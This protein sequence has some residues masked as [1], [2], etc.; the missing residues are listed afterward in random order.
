MYK[1]YAN[2]INFVFSAPSDNIIP[3]IIPCK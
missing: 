1:Y 3:L 2:F